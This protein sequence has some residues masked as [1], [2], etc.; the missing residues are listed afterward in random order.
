MWQCLTLC[1]ITEKNFQSYRLI[2]IACI[3]GTGSC[4]K[5]MRI[6]NIYIIFRRWW[7]HLMVMTAFNIISIDRNPI[8]PLFTS[9]FWRSRMK[10]RGR[11]WIPKFATDIFHK[12]EVQTVILRCQVG[13]NPNWFK[14]FD[15]KRKYFPFQFFFNF[16]KNLLFLNLCNVFSAFCI[17]CIFLHLCHNFWTN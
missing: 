15:T 6:K 13:Q 8:D 7:N 4:G 17:F 5:T 1:I 12:T 10:E 3:W 11:G 14:S 9:G 16:V 2:D